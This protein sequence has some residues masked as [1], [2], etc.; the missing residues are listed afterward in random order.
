MQEI[1][2][3]DTYVDFQRTKWR[4]IPEYGTLHN[5]GCQ[6]FKSYKLRTILQSNLTIMNI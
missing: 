3:S 2:S 5:D 4:Y 1:C 6:N